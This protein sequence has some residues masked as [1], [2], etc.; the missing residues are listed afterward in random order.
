MA[1][2]S[3]ILSP[4]FHLSS[5]PPPLPQKNLDLEND[6]LL[7]ITLRF[8]DSKDACTAVLEAVLQKFFGVVRGP[9]RR[10]EMLPQRPQLAFVSAAAVRVPTGATAAVPSKGGGGCDSLH[11]SSSTNGWVLFYHS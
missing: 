10:A 1:F 7:T 9:S 5:L 11:H 3:L 4:S 6:A 2:F 8:T